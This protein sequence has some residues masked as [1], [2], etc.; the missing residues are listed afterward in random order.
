MTTIATRPNGE[1]YKARKPPVTE[2]LNGD[3]DDL[4]LVIRCADL[5]E[6]KRMAEERVREYDSQCTVGPGRFGWWH[7]GIRNHETFWNE[8]EV[9][10]APGWVFDI[11]E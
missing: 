5:G 7:Q 4:I 9:R 3:W 10:G 8:D 11:V 6:A 2:I 1:T